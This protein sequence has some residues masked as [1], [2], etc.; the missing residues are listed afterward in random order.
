MA[1]RAPSRFE[2]VALMAMLVSTVAFSIDAMLPALPEIAAELAPEAPNRAQLI[3]TAFF[4]GLGLG[5][6]VMG[7]VS[8]RFGRKPVILAGL[9]LYVAG[10]VLAWAAP[11]LELLLLARVLQGIGAAAPRVVSLAII[12]DLHSGR[13]MARLVSFVM[14]IF[15]LFPAVAPLLGSLIMEAGGSWRAVFAAFV[16]FATISAVWLMLRLAE[17]LPPSSR[18]PL[19]PRPM[20]DTVI[21]MFQHP[22]VRLSIAVQTLCYAMLF[23]SIGAIQPVFDLA[24]GRADSFP[25][26]FAGIALVA[27]SAS[28]LNAALVMRLGMRRLVTFALSVQCATTLGVLL[29]YLG[30]GTTE[31]GFFVF[32][33]W[34]TTVFFMVG[35]TLGNL[36][37]IAMDPM[38][39]VAGMAASVIGSVA[40][41]LAAAIAVP[42]SLAFDGTPVPLA[43]GVFAVTAAAYGLML[44]MGRVERRLPA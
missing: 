16:V 8:D 40:S 2:F 4:V 7:P 35:M 10:A 23:M 39:H 19:R 37:A 22:T 1:T 31:A 36:N 18:R 25:Y 14:L 3:L 41:V 13:A 33:G 21:E 42:V 43:A 17:T 11:T 34:Q 20:W 9:A 30:A 32:I 27:G 15:T 38:G 44:H 26:W 28:L 6:F 5:T 24:F 12:R 29:Y